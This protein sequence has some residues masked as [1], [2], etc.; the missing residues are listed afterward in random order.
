MEVLTHTME[1]CHLWSV[2][3]KD[4]S[5]KFFGREPSLQAKVEIDC[6]QFL[7][8]KPPLRMRGRIL[9]LAGHPVLADFPIQPGRHAMCLAQRQH[10]YRFEMLQAGANWFEAELVQVRPGWITRLRA[11][12]G[13]L[14]TA[15]SWIREIRPADL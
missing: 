10:C 8:E 15:E 6:E 9:E 3:V 13:H 4:V 11:R 7:A 12:L 2:I 14:A 1:L 5:L